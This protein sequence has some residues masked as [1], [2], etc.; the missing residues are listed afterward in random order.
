MAPLDDEKAVSLESALSFFM[1]DLRRWLCV[2][3]FINWRVFPHCLIVCRNNMF[4]FVLFV[5]LCEDIVPSVCSLDLWFLIP[6]THS[7]SSKSEITSKS[8]FTTVDG[9]YNIGANNQ[10]SLFLSSESEDISLKPHTS[11]FLLRNSWH[12]IQI[13]FEF[14]HL[15]FSQMALPFARL[16]T[17]SDPLMICCFISW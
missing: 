12:L 6:K 9:A 14:C 13:V 8:Q 5:L 7:K 4:P 15:V 11:E 3:T 16:S 1:E 2:S 10:I 17:W